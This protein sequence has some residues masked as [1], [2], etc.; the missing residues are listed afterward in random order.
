M[1]HYG[2]KLSRDYIISCIDNYVEMYKISP[3]KKII[4]YKKKFEVVD[5]ESFNSDTESETGAEGENESES[6]S[7]SESEC[8]GGN[9]V[10]GNTENINDTGAEIKYTKTA[11]EEKNEMCDI[12][13]LDYD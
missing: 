3:G 10:V 9:I 5:D 2:V 11:L 12:E 7:E 1:E 4:V 6:E 13:I 8:E